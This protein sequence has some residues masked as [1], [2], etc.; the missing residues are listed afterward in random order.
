MNTISLRSVPVPE[1]IDQLP[2]ITALYKEV[3]AAPPWNEAYRCTCCKQSFGKEVSVGTLCCSQPLVEYY[4]F[5]ETLDEIRGCFELSRARVAVVLDSVADKLVGFSWGW[6]DNLAQAN[7]EKFGMNAD[8]V[9]RLC[10]VLKVSADT[11]FFYLSEFG[12]QQD[13][14]G[15]GLGKGLYTTL[16]DDRDRSQSDAIIMRTSKKSPAFSI[17]TNNP[18]YPLRVAYEYRDKLE[19]VILAS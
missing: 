5:A 18:R 4:P 1:A 12:V 13:Y 7:A 2:L 14:R 10:K 6:E 17:A 9:E 19:R 8:E 3:F 11:L 16:L 15:K